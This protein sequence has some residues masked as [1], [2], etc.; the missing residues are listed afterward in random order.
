[1]DVCD[2]RSMRGAEI[3]SDHFLVRAKIRLK[4]ERS[5]KIK[6]SE[7]KKC[8][9]NK[10]KKKEVKEEFIKVVTANIQ[11]KNLE[12]EDINEIW[13][14]IKKGVNEAAGKI[15]EKEERPQRIS[16]FDEECHTILED[17]KR[18]YNK[19]INRNTRQNEQEYK[20]KRKESH[21][22]FRQKKR[23]CLNHSWKKLKLL[24]ITMK[25]INFIKK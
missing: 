16:W 13:N 11:N 14:K 19:V 20:D 21:K 8:D 25:Q 18:A 15:I 3:E 4:I 12:V 23:V 17:K 6:K 1:M 5:E 22:I 7:I 24:I 10:L 9:I 2:V